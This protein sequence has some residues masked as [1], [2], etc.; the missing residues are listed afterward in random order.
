M[1]PS[2]GHHGDGHSFTTYTFVPSGVTATPL[3]YEFCPTFTVAVT[4]FVV[5]LITETLS[6]PEFATYTFDPSRA[7]CNSPRHVT[8]VNFGCD[9]ICGCVNY[10]DIIAYRVRDICKCA[11]P[12]TLTSIKTKAV[13]NKAIEH[14]FRLVNMCYSPF[15]YNVYRVKLEDVLLVWNFIYLLHI[16][17]TSLALDIKSTSIGYNHKIYYLTN[18]IHF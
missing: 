11:A 5:V 8:Y 9:S 7:D 6:L 10:R 18:Y 4:A 15:P 16:I 1:E 12:A 3:E 17:I 2:G 13:E 14:K